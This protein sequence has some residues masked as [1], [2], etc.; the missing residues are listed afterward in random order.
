[1]SLKFGTIGEI[2]SSYSVL[3][4]SIAVGDSVAAILAGMEGLWVEAVD[5]PADTLEGVNDL[6]L[7]VRITRRHQ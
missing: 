7:F 5:W 1:M 4:M 2:E 6:R 3:A